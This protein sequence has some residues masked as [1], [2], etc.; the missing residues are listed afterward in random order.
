[1]LNFLSKLSHGTLLIVL[2]ELYNDLALARD[3]DFIKETAVMIGLVET[4]LDAEV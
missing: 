4:V 3:P 2:R 1:M